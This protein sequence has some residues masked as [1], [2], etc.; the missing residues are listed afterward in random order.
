MGVNGAEVMSTQCGWRWCSGD[1]CPVGVNGQE[2]M[3]TQCGW[4]WSSGDECPVGDDGA[5]VMSVPCGWPRATASHL[6][7]LATCPRPVDHEV[8]PNVC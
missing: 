1:E 5:E 3:S 2:G 8:D 4:R 7:S 6:V